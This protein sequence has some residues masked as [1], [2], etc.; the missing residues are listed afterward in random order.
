M[1]N[2]HNLVARTIAAVGLAVLTVNPAR[3]ANQGQQ[4]AKSTWPLDHNMRM[5]MFYTSDTTSTGEFPGRL[6]CLR[7]VLDSVPSPVEQCA[8]KDHVYVLSME[9]GAMVHPLLPGDPRTLKRL[10]TLVGKRV[11]VEGKYYESIGMILASHVRGTE[12]RS[13]PQTS[14]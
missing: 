10:P 7:S 8:K 2:V 6:L 3:G 1:N 4:T 13:D 14:R 11:V 12:A 9:R 5:A